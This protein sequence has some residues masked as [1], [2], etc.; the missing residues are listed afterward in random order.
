MRLL[1]LL[2]LFALSFSQHVKVLYSNGKVE[3]VDTRKTPL[4][5][6]RARPDVVYVEPPIKLKLLDDI[7][8]SSS[9]AIRGSGNYSFSIN[10]QSGQRLSIL[11]GGASVSFSGSCSGSIDNLICNSGTLNLSVSSSSDWRLIVQ[12]FGRNLQLSDFSTTAY[13]IGTGAV[14]TG[15][16]GRNVI[17]GIIDTGIDWC[18]PAFRRSDGS[19]KI[20]Y[21]Y[22]PETNTQYTRTQIEQFISE[23]RCDGDPHGHGTYVAGIASYIAPDADLIVVRTNLY[24]TDIIQGL[25]Y[26]RNKKDSL[27]RPM[28]VNMS[29]G[30][31]FGPHDGTS[32]LERAIANLSGNGF[33]VVAAA[34][35]EGH[36]KLYAK[37]SGIS[38]TV[39][40][41]LNSPDPEGDVVDGWYKN[42]TLRVEI[43][44]VL[45]NCITA[46]PETSASGRLYCSVYIDN[47]TTSH[48]L[49]GDGRFVVYF[50]CGGE[51]IIRLTPRSGTPNADLYLVLEESEF[52]DCFLDDGFGG[53]LG[54]VV[55]PAT[56]PYVIAVGALT[57]RFRTTT[58]MSFI[59]LG[60]IA[61]FSSRGPTRDGR[62]KPE[63]VAPGYFVLGPEAGTSDYILGAGTSP[64]SPVVA[65]LVA[66]ILEANPNLDVNGVRG[67]LSSQALSD[68][69]TGSL[70]NNIYGYGKAFLSSFS[71][72]GSV[73]SIYIGSLENFTCGL[74]GGSSGGSGS[75]TGD[76]GGAG[77]G[78]GGSGGTG[79]GGS[80]GGG[81]NSASPD[82][83]IALL[84]LLSVALLRRLAKKKVA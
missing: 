25:Q 12:S 5:V 6:L 79:G 27:G 11:A 20:L 74:R 72:V 14:N 70:P 30:G 3:V 9:V 75:G 35:N 37:V 10:T 44:D 58:G 62:L 78:G 60:K 50:N 83:Y 77:G 19:S 65:G 23:G 46:E 54:T 15:R 17:I 13:Y 28:V 1:I 43:C 81:C 66:L 4:S 8:Y 2:L 67:V 31:H 82:L 55:Q 21:Y 76:T 47:T 80:G 16:T 42:G 57:S 51:Y 24:D 7:V 71:S 53:F 48:P 61:F 52:L 40:V 45:N 18:H 36:K 34:G 26:L 59:D 22:V 29:L 64:A 56:S 41:R 39:S 69:F 68:G 84:A 49:N 63:V 33:V 32:M 73:G 38:S